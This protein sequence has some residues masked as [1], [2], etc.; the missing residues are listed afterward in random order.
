MVLVERKKS[1]EPKTELSDEINFSELFVI[2]W[3]GK[4]LVF[5]VSLLGLAAAVFYALSVPNTY[6]SEALLAPNETFGG[7]DIPSRYSELAS[8]AGLRLNT[9]AANNKDLGI[10]VLKSRRF[11]FEFISSHDLLVPLMA[12]NGWDA[13]TGELIIDKGIYD[14]VGHEWIRDIEPPKRPE[15]SLQE[16]FTKFINDHLS[17]VENRTT[18]F[19]KIS[20]DHYSPYIA[21]QWVDWLVQDINRAIMER[22]VSQ[23]EQ[24]I[25]YLREQ[26]NETSL[27][28]LQAVFFRLIEDQI[29]TVVLAKASPEYLLKTIDP[30]IVSEEKSGPNRFLLVAI[31][32]AVSFFVG[33]F[34]QLTRHSL[35]KS[36]R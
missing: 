11:V 26:V 27:A 1:G 28:E 5:L 4:W 3:S 14:P 20:I 10:E 36:N 15:P 13:K 7:N 17:V 25:T 23:A 18:G 19:V 8:L 29:R 31:G 9:G 6:R 12:A 33:F 21:K 22:D 34:V 30:A 35:S 32:L 16:A 24:A 2:L